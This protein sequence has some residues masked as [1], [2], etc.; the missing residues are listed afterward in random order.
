MNDWMTFL[1]EDIYYFL[2]P[3]QILQSP[4][5][6]SKVYKYIT[7]SEN[8]YNEFILSNVFVEENQRNI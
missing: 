7:K 6:S 4:E 8:F 5:N 3:C 1:S 2:F